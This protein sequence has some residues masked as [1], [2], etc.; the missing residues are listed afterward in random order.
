VTVSQ[1]ITPQFPTGELPFCKAV[2][3]LAVPPYQSAAPNVVANSMIVSFE[4]PFRR[5]NAKL[6]RK[7]NALYL[8]QRK[9]TIEPTE[10]F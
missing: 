9:I 10:V 6:T 7:P 3:I 1:T 8:F 5:D 2:K 4:S